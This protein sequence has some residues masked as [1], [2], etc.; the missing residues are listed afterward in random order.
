MVGLEAL[1]LPD[2]N[3]ELSFRLALRVAYVLNPSDNKEKK[4]YDFIRKM[5]KK[6]SN[7]VHGSKYSLSEEEVYKIEGFL[8][9]S[10][11]L[12]INEKIIFSKANLDNIFFK[13]F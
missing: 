2:G 8:R 12:W 4:P 11:K 10:I 7:I 13:K 3:D 5:Y 6:R 1:Y 9:A